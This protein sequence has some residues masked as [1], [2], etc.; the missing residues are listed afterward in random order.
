MILAVLLNED[1]GALGLTGP[2]L[3]YIYSRLV[4]KSW[5]HVEPGYDLCV[6]C[7]TRRD[8]VQ[9]KETLPNSN[10]V[11]CKDIVTF[12]RI[13]DLILLF[14][15]GIKQSVC[16]LLSTFALFN[17]FSFSF[18]QNA[19]SFS[20]SLGNGLNAERDVDADWRKSCHWSP[21][22]LDLSHASHEKRR[23][24]GDRAFTPVQKGEHM[25]RQRLTVQR[26]LHFT[27]DIL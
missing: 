25:Q 7:V 27:E 24:S 26:P 14:W 18:S 20:E 11:T 10:K 3:L 8:A 16:C 4:T 23:E 5:D 21:A 19:Q 17:T 2:S 6:T 13:S 9:V 1:V 12:V 22:S 15:K